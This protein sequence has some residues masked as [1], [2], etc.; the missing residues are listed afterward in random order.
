MAIFHLYRTPAISRSAL[1][2]LVERARHRGF[3]SLRALRSE[4][5]FN[6][7]TSRPLDSKERETLNWLLRETFDP[8]GFGDHSFLAADLDPADP[9]ATIL[10]VGPRMSFTTAWSTNAVSVCHACGLDAVLRI[11]RS[12]RFL[13]DTEAEPRAGDLASFLALVHDRM[14]ECPYPEPLSSFDAGVAPAEVRTVPVLEEGRAALER[15]DQEMGLAFDDWDL[16]YYTKLFTERVG[17]NPT[18]VECF[19][20]AQSNSEHSRHWFFKGRLIVDGVEQPHS[21]MDLVAAPLEAAQNNSVIAFKDNSSALRGYR[22]ATILPR[23]PGTPGPL[24]LTELDYDLILTAETHNF[25][26]GVA[27]YPGAETGTGGRIRDTHATGRGSL[28]VAGTA[29]YCVGNLQ[30]PGYELPWE[31]PEFGYPDNLAPP[32]QIEIEASNGASD[33][34][35]KFGEPVIQGY[36]RSFGMRLPDGERREWIKPIMFSAGVG[37]IDARHLEKETPAVGMWVVKLGGPAYRIGMGGGAASSMVQGENAAELDFNAVQRGDAEMEQKVNRVLRACVEMGT[38]NPIVSIHDQGAGGNCNVLKEI[39]EPAGARIHVRAVPVGDDTL[40][41]L[42][43]WGAEYQENDALLLRPEHKEL[44]QH[45]CEREKVT[46]GFVGRVTGDGKIVLHDERDDSTPVDLELDAVLGKMPRKVFEMDRHPVSAQPLALPDQLSVSDALDRVLRLLSVG[47]K[48]FLT[49]KV[50]RSVTGLVA[51]QQCA[52]PLLLTVADVAVIAQSHFSNTGSATAIGEQPIKGMLD[53][54]AMARLCVGEA[55]TNLVWARV[56][57][58]TDVKCSGNWMWAAKLPGEG[59]ALY[60]AA[61]ALSNVM[62]ALGIAIDGGKDSLSMAALA[63]GADGN[64]EVVKGPGTLVISAYCSCPDVAATV[65]PDLELPESGRLLFV[66]LAAGRRR[67]GGSALAQVYGQL[68]ES[69]PDLDDPAV[70]A[71]AFEA[72]QELIEAGVVTAGHDVSDGGLITGALEMAFSGNCGLELDV[73]GGAEGPIAALFAEELGLLLEVHESNMDQALEVFASA[74]VPCSAIGRARTGTD[75]AVRVDGDTVLNADVRDLRDTWEA[76]SFE[77]DRRQADPGHVEQERTGVRERRTPAYEL[78][79]EPAPTAPALLTADSKPKIAILREEGSNGDREMSSA[80]YAAGFEPWDVVMSDLLEGSMN[81]DRFRGVA[82]V[83][84]FSYADVLDSAKGWAGVIRF[85]KELADQFASFRDRPD[86]F[87]L[88]LCNGCQLSALLGWVPWA[89]IEDEL[90]PRFVHNASGRFESRF[91]TVRVESSPAIMF[92]GME[93]SVLGVASAHAEGRAYFPDSAI[94]Q[95]VQDMGLA[96]LRFADDAGET[97]ERY[98]FNPN[99]S[100]AGIAGLCSPDGRHLALMPHPERTFLKW[101][102]NW[103]PATWRR[104]LAVSPWLRMFQNARAWCD[105]T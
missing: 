29:A 76:T 53:P 36:T 43:I 3:E 52:G 96:P 33:Y 47:S 34:G 92:R 97:T 2:A 70:L 17:R 51:R 71:R 24:E 82:F 48:R 81:L 46:V 54:A 94:L 88:G 56:S 14:T 87:S 27:P 32:L 25:P 45:L 10:E 11:E 61:V 65:T 50:D 104:E 63:P 4:Y 89:G 75:I 95:K 93:G 6:V 7:A 23:E 79:Y 84:G 15:I 18:D 77:L 26:S 13:L 78:T 86:T 68:G 73:P 64:D 21:L 19:D 38:N 69:S 28:V 101:Q 16:D 20:I 55:L 35:N 30:I 39:V 98:P 9:R 1:D 40:S 22:I 80:F 58:L 60:D 37:Q 59:A 67:L 12:R 83:G 62:L 74:E 91:P 5:C 85:H 102:W 31:D 100:P 66:D 99:G 103:M 72:V 49:T 105:N 8:R 44:F 41:V 90:Q 57:A 42:E